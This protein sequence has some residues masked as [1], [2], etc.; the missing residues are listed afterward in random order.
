[1]SLT[2]AALA[3]LC[4]VP[5]LAVKPATVPARGQQEAILTIDAAGM[6]HLSAR[7]DSGTACEIVDHLRGPFDSSGASGTSNCEL[8]LLLDSGSYKLRLRS[9]VKGKGQVAL[10]VAPF[11]ELNPGGV[12]LDERQSAELRLAPGQQVSHWIHNDKPRRVDLI[13]AGRSAG[14]VR[15][16]RN[17][18]WVEEI[19]AASEQLAPRPGQPIWLWHLRGRLEAGD[20]LLVAYGAR[21]QR[22]TRG[23]EDDALYV[24][25]GFALAPAERTLDFALPAW[26]RLWIEIGAGPHFATL[27]LDQAPAAATSLEFWELDSAGG[28][29]GGRGGSCSV[30]AKAVAPACA[31]SASGKKRHLLVVTGEP[32]T[33]G[34]LQW[35]PRPKGLL[36]DGE[37]LTQGDLEFQAPAAGRYLIGLHDVPTDFDA[38][39]LGC[40]LERRQPD[41]QWQR[42]AVDALRIDGK[43]PFS[44]Q[45][46][47]REQGYTLW[48]EL[49]ESGEYRIASSGE[50][51]AICE[52]YQGDHRLTKSDPKAKRCD[53][54]L[55]LGPGQYQLNFYG[56]QAGIEKLVID[57]EG[58]LL[59][60]VIDRFT[61]T[62]K[63]DQPPE[64]QPTPGKSGCRFSDVALAAGVRYRI[65]TNR[66]GEVQARGLVLRPLPLTL[67]TPLPIT[68]DGQ[69]EVRLPSA[70]GRAGLVRGVGALTCALRSGA[71]VAGRDGVCALPALASGDEL[72]LT[73]RSVDGVTAVVGRP[74][75]RPPAPVLASYAPR[76]AP[77]PA[78]GVG[79]PIYLDFDRSE[80][81]SLLFDVAEAGLYHLTTEGLLATECRLRTPVA[82]QLARDRSGGRGRNCLLAGYLRPGRYL[83]T[84]KT[85]GQ[86]RGRASV[87]LS[88]R[89]ATRGPAVRADGEVFFRARA[90]DLVQQELSVGQKGRYALDTS[91]Q[92]VQLQCR[93]DDRDG[94]PL[95]AVPT[96]CRA[97]HELA[98]GRYRWSQLPLTVES[99]RRTEIRRV[100]PALVLRGNKRR[101]A[102]DVNT[103]Y[104]AEL[105][106]DG[107][108]EFQ[109]TLSADLPVRVAL[110][111]GMQG[112]LYRV[113]GDREKLIETVPPA[114]PP[115]AGSE[116]DEEE[117]E[118]EYEEEPDEMPVEE[119]GEDEGYDEGGDGE[120]EMPDG[121]GGDVDDEGDGALSDGETP[122]PAYQPPPA[123][124]RRKPSGDD[125]LAVDLKAGRYRL[126]TEH[127]RGDVAI[128]YRLRVVSEVLAPG[129][130]QELPVP[131]SATVRMPA[132]GM[133]HLATRGQTDVRCRLFA[134]GGA[135]L[136]ESADYGADWNCRLV[137][138]LPAGDYRLVFEAQN[139]RSGSTRVKVV[140]PPDRRLDRLVDGAKLK[141]ANQA[142]VVPLPAVEG[143]AVQELHFRSKS[144]FSC[145][146]ERG[147][148]TVLQRED[149]VRHCQLLVHAAGQPFNVRLWTKGRWA[150]LTASHQARPIGKLH[151]RT[152]AAGRAGR[153]DIARPGRY[154]T[155]AN[156]WCRPAAEPGL[157]SPCGPSAP[158][159][160]GALVVSTVGQR[161]E[162]RLD[163]DE[164]V[165]ELSA[166]DNPAVREQ[167]GQRR[168]IERQRSGQPGLHLVAVRVPF[169]EAAAPACRLEGGVAEQQP[170]ACFAASGATRESL[171]RLWAATDKPLPATVTRIAALIPERAATLAPG[172][173]EAT[174]SGQ[175]GRF[176]LPDAPFQL[177]ATLPPQ[178]WAVQLDR[179]GAAIDFC[180]P[181]EALSRCLLAGQGGELLLRGGDGSRLQARL[182]LVDAAPPQVVLRGLYEALPLQHG[183]LRL[184]V[185]P[186]AGARLVE[187]DGEVRCTITRDDGSRSGGC[188]GAIPARQG[189]EVVINHPPGP[190][191]AVVFAPGQPNVARWSKL[192]PRKLPPPLGEARAIPIKPGVNDF[193]VEI[194]QRSLLDVR[195]D[196]GVGAL[197]DGTRLLKLDGLGGACTL[198]RLLEPGRYRV[199]LR[200]F[201]GAPATGSVSWTAEPVPALADGVGAEQWIAPGAARYF[202]FRTTSA[203]RVGLGL[204]VDADRLECTVLDV[205]HRLLGHG[206]QQ[207]LEL[208]AGNYLLAVRAPPELAPQRFRPVL[209]GLK[210]SQRDVP[211]EYLRDFFQRIGATP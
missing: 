29:T 129:L 126:V 50:T 182:L 49:L 196:S 172:K 83:A 109:F 65:R 114:E 156:V 11:A 78:I 22:W 20:Y 60:S 103:W 205:N 210:G 111:N 37:Y 145:A 157:L 42:M 70:A 147:D 139:Q 113:D 38:P 107:R 177:E 209:L 48:F 120:E 99:M 98:R 63:S 131:G 175:V 161:D 62:K 71:P 128:A 43:H 115:A 80:S 108:D 137:E 85:V 169:G 184:R 75:P 149:S 192:L 40:A 100:R 165:I 15:L 206:C 55:R 91:G 8:D 119:G 200:P 34:Q 168:L 28:A 187:V 46:N 81:H 191:R 195:A 59:K 155:A 170:H 53:L 87:L 45:F 197:F 204:Q 68:V 118:Q 154:R 18:Q 94:W 32:G 76:F 142:L 64:I 180:P 96:P 12:R 44:R 124:A 102:I 92:G 6:Y 66:L 74:R 90:G 14:L 93:L 186:A 106:R 36:A 86:S 116:E 146:L 23:S 153:V 105:G 140:A 125:N 150:E 181:G 7:S 72:I 13:V 3:L 35:A 122:D 82:P 26:G 188:R 183:Q 88:R 25:N 58:G 41:R 134:A 176:A 123:A 21:P 163:L 174:W 203:G 31:T 97:S 24:A 133:L 17:G 148:G 132:A 52:L 57:R 171:L 141:T 95:V 61:N 178:T 10:A 16:W 5:G 30:A 104:D 69:S 160:A 173:S 54:K 198:Q 4:A 162:L 211:E 189:A 202:S 101:H 130:Q 89:P 47:L 144:A 2:V 135:L 51:R 159:E 201:A 138:P 143:D 56:G 151:G 121:S 208:P 179:A 19:E 117:Y 136:A 77:I 207:F 1:M 79:K 167:L 39:P 33:G 112:R 193:T 194:R 190:L 67:D 158:L 199:M 164:M 127:C 9:P 110:T 27:S 73:N 152:V 185:P 84:A 166:D